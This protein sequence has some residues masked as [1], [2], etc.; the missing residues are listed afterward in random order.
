MSR[1]FKDF[2]DAKNERAPRGRKNLRNNSREAYSYFNGA[3]DDDETP[4][5]T[6]N[7]SIFMYSRVGRGVSG[8][9]SN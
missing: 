4:E 3:D 2:Q 8:E 1:S 7:S 9:S 5:S 6:E